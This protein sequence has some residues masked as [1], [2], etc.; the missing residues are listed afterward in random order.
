MG[1]CRQDFQC[2]YLQTQ[3]EGR[4]DNKKGKD[5]ELLKDQFRIEINIF[6][7]VL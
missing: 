3:T 2:W 6:L 4:W 7:M 1:D 5:G